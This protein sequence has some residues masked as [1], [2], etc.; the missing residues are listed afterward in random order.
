MIAKNALSDMPPRLYEAEAQ[1]L[2][3]FTKKADQAEGCQEVFH[4]LALRVLKADDIYVQVPYDEG[5]P[6]RNQLSA[7]SIS[8]R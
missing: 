4:L 6:P 3:E 8:V 2:P 1:P 5:V 7:S